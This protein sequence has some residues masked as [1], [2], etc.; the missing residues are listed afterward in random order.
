MRKETFEKDEANTLKLLTLKKKV[1][2]NSNSVKAKQTTPI[3]EETND[4]NV[5]SIKKDM[6]CS[7][8]S[9][10]VVIESS[11]RIQRETMCT[12]YSTANP[13]LRTKPIFEKPVRFTSAKMLSPMTGTRVQTMVTA[14]NKAP[15][16]LPMTISF[17][18]W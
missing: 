14:I 9:K 7:T 6:V 18:Q 16:K 2:L 15:T 8:R 1:E 5:G 11:A 10:L 13:T 12:E 4:M 3:V 17:M